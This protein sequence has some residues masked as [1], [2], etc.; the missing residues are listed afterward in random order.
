MGI[1][2]DLLTDLAN[3][4]KE[5]STVK[6]YLDQIVADERD[7]LIT[8]DTDAVAATPAEWQYY[9]QLV[10]GGTYDLDIDVGEETIS[11]TGL[12]FDH[13][14]ADLLAA[15]NSAAGGGDITG[16]TNGDIEVDSGGA[17]TANPRTLTFSG[18][19]VIGKTIDF[20]FDGTNLTGGTPDFAASE[21]TEY[22][23]GTTE[24]PA[25]ALLI[26][27]GVISGTAPA[28][29]VV[30]TNEFTAA[31]PLA[32]PGHYPPQEVIKALLAEI[33]LTEGVSW[34]PYMENLLGIKLS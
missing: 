16:W 29:G 33:E 6:E 18:D 30:P 1:A 22:V 4:L 11:L 21:E 26:A 20:T 32:R 14:G 9:V 7:T 25:V 24:R 15:I 23:A 28:F 13:D 27:L 17:L 10:S 34:V 3:K 12:A 5:G 8:S 31:G 2:N 19:S